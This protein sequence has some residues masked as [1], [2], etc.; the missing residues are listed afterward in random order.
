M[1]L[2]VEPTLKPDAHWLH[3]W[4]LLHFL[5]LDLPFLHLERA[6]PLG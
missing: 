6:R 5:Q 1:Q 2:P 4:A 3:L